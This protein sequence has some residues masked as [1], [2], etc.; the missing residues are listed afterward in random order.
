MSLILSAHALPTGF[1]AVLLVGVL[2]SASLGG[3]PTLLSAGYKVERTIAAKEVHTYTADLTVGAAMIANA[4]QEGIDIAI[5]VYDPDGQWVT[6]L[7]S[8]NGSNGPEPIRV[9]AFMTGMYRF[10]VKALDASA[11]PGKYLLTVSAFLTPEENAMA[12]AKR[13]FAST[14]PAILK[15]WQDAQTNPDAVETF[16]ASRKGMGPFV[17]TNPQNDEEMRVTFVFPGDGDTQ[18][19]T[20]N[21]APSVGGGLPM[22]RIPS[23]TM[24]Y[25]STNVPKDARFSYSFSVREMHYPGAD[26]RLFVPES[27]T[28]PDPFGKNMM[29]G[30][31]Y[32]EMPEAP[33]SPIPFHN[34]AR[35]RAGSNRTAS[36]APFCRRV[37]G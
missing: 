28:V 37:A 7:D 2:G 3:E 5:D 12:I 21:G 32:V 29:S 19:V 22:A 16:I 15:L 36:G 31:S 9:T 25:A 4:E 35:R 20:V 26:H 8:P 17:E 6:T 10:A 27:K 14:H 18:D 33:R 23:T 13:E 11:A 34:A 1:A 30:Q 24:F